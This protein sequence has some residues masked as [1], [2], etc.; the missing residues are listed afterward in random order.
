MLSF[1]HTKQISK[2][3]A[4]KQFPDEIVNIISRKVFPIFQKTKRNIKLKYLLTKKKNK[5]Q[6]HVILR[7]KL[8]DVSKKQLTV[9]IS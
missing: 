9:D 1:R 5:N 2:N 4:V 8:H 6:S 3:I 7:K